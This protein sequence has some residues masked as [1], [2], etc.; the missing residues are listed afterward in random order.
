[1]EVTAESAFA[2]KLNR[3]PVTA[4]GKVI[5]LLP[6]DSGSTPHQKFVI[7]IHSGHT[8][9]VS[10]NLLRAYRMPVKIGDR[11]EVR[12]TY[13]WNRFGGLI[14]NTHHDTGEECIGP[15]CEP[16]EDGY[17]NLVGINKNP[18]IEYGIPSNI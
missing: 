6:D 15:A 7:E 8:I 5:R 10:H 1:M 9:L 11:V 2:R 14:H 16:H 17:I 12:G 18:H 4:T 13:I 3:V